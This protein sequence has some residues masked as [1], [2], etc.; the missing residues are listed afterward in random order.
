MFHDKKS[1]IKILE[2]TQRKGMEEGWGEELRQQEKYILTQLGAQKKVGGYF[3][4]T[5]VKKPMAT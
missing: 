5:E 3:L 1:L 4:E 2:D